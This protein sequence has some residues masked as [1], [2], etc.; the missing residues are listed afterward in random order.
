MENSTK[1]YGYL[2]MSIKRCR[3]TFF[4]IYKVAC[5][6]SPMCPIFIIRKALYT[7]TYLDVRETG[8]NHQNR[9]IGPSTHFEGSGT[10]LSPCSFR[11]Y[12]HTDYLQ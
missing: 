7:R 6:F 9:H 10:E 8:L 3:K 5:N 1:M 12:T 2:W 4:V 11:S